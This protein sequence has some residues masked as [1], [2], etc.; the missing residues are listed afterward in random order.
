[1][2]LPVTITS[3]NGERLTFL[4]I[5]EDEKG[6]EILEVENEVAP[7]AGPPMHVHHQQDEWL[8]VIEGKIGYQELGKEKQYA[9]PGASVLFKAGVAHR[10]WNA[11]T[12]PLRCTGWISPPH[13]IIYFLSEIYRSSNENKGRPGAFDA[14]FLLDRYKSEF[15][16]LD[17]PHFVQKVIFPATLFLGKLRGYH[18]KF[19]NA[20]LP[21]RQ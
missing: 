21:V 3:I 15:A 4:R 16:M 7:N 17:I 10:F 12:T 19:D 18:R 8:A 13:N 14:A 2:Q 20:P 9:G 11:G 1:M 6:R 5:I